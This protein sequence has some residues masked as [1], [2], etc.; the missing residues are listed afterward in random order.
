M[1][2]NNDQV[3]RGIIM[4][5]YRGDDPCGDVLTEHGEV[6]GSWQMSPDE[7]C[8]FTPDGQSE[9]ILEAP[10]PWKLH[11]SIADWYADSKNGADR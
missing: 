9:S 3:R 8:F 6:L 4:T 1:D 11:D 10:S 5:G 7:W 2:E